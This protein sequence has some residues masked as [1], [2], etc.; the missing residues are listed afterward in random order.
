MTRQ[1][2]PDL[3]DL[4]QI[5]PYGSSRFAKLDYADTGKPADGV[6][7]G[8]LCTLDY[9]IHHAGTVFRQASK[10]IVPEQI[11]PLVFSE[12]ETGTLI[13]APTGAGKGTAVIMPTL[14]QYGQSVFVIDPK[15]ENCAVTM[16]RRKELGQA[17]HVLNPWD[18]L[19]FP[20]ACIN[21]L[22]IVDPNSRDAVSK[23]SLLADLLVVPSKSEA[24]NYWNTS[25]HALIR[26]IIL[27]VAGHET[28]RTLD[29]V[30]RVLSQGSSDLK[31]TFDRMASS[32]LYSGR[33]S[34]I[35]HELRDSE[36]RSFGDVLSTARSHLD[37]LIDP[38]VTES[39]GRSDFSFSDL[40]T[41]P[42]SVFVI[43]PLDKIAS[44]S[45]WLRLTVGLAIHGIQTVPKERCNNR[46]LFLLDEFP[47]LGYMDAVRRGVAELRGFGADFCL[48]VQDLSQLRSIYHDDA[49]NI[50]ANCAFKWFSRISDPETAGYLSNM[51]GSST[52]S[53]ESKTSST[54]SGGGSSST[55]TSL[56]GIPLQ[57]EDSI[58]RARQSRAFLLKSGSYPILIRKAPYFE[59]ELLRKYAD[60]NP[61]YKQTK[62]LEQPTDPAPKA[63]AKGGF[64]AGLKRI[65]DRGK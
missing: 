63:E 57:S 43:I 10:T 40:T 15:G 55:S 4:N 39:L 31:K 13:C 6:H 20:N 9:T 5:E 8:H 28:T 56:T 30:R 19:G 12:P 36:A 62:A 65:F 3:F 42:T 7:F 32:E 59:N 1:R 21:P 26:G 47:A 2:V 14:L 46:C 54:G 51:L 25:A 50:K 61:Y 35:G 52:V 44:Q 29:T 38:I 22:D 16:R 23:A 58:M 37:F 11:G 27:Y 49:D 24:S 33:L 18:V 64:R 53:V 34:E 41:T 60:P 45:R 48:V 17:V